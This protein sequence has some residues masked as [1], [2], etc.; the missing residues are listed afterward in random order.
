MSKGTDYVF[1]AAVYA[2]AQAR[3]AEIALGLEMETDP[4]KLMALQLELTALDGSWITV[5]PNTNPATLT[6][7][8]GIELTKAEE[9]KAAAKAAEK[10]AAK[11]KLADIAKNP[12]K[13]QDMAAAIAALAASINRLLG[14]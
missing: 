2:R 12:P 9:A 4:E 14:D 8:E 5:T 7:E 10:A 6:E 13:P 11:A 1:N 3:M